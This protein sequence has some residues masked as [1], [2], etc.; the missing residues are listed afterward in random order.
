MLS[1]KPENCVKS[2]QKLIYGTGLNFFFLL[3][4]LATNTTVA[5]AVCFK[6]SLTLCHEFSRWNLKCCDFFP[7]FFT[8]YLFKSITHTH[9]R[10]HTYIHHLHD[11]LF[12]FSM[13]CFSFFRIFVAY[14][15]ALSLGFLLGS[16]I[17]LFLYFSY[18]ATIFKCGSK[19]TSI[20]GCMS[21]IETK[22]KKKKLF[23][24]LIQTKTRLFIYR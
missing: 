21:F 18:A 13:K 20:W 7:G 23:L 5:T 4:F 14:F 1:L 16:F 22:Q 12:I 24:S 9:T 6:V 17:R 11:F 15:M 2:Q 8:F 10:L 19:M 3:C